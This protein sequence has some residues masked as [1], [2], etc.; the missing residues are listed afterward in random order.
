MCAPAAAFAENLHIARRTWTVVA[1]PIAWVTAAL[2]LATTARAAEWQGIGAPHT[3]A[4]PPHEKCC[5][6][7]TLT[8][9]RGATSATIAPSH[10][11]AEAQTTIARMAWTFTNVLSTLQLLAAGI[12][13]TK[14]FAATD[15][16][17]L[18]SSTI[19]KLHRSHR[20]RWARTI[21]TPH[22]A[23]MTSTRQ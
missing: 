21:M 1:S 3:F 15:P 4:N 14:S 16:F 9:S 13:T 23:C 18:V 19:T 12:A 5:R 2:S 11:I 22:W 6:C 10:R 20:A 7:F 17:F 8:I